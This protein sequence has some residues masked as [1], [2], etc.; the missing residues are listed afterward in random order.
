MGY[1]TPKMKLNSWCMD[2]NIQK[3]KQF[4]RIKARPL[5]WWFWIEKGVEETEDSKIKRLRRRT[6]KD[7]WHSVTSSWL[8]HRTFQRLARCMEELYNKLFHQEIPLLNSTG[9]QITLW[10]ILTTSY[11]HKKVLIFYEGVRR[12]LDL[13]DFLWW[14]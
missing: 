3:Q 9:L 4:I 6:D 8:T 7:C 11:Y 2:T 5:S 10:I 14:C 1:Q 13:I 12:F